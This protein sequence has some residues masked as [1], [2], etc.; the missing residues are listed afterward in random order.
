VHR[1]FY[2]DREDMMK[3]K[4]KGKGAERD[5]EGHRWKQK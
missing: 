4:R 5:R 1:F 2:G 3:R